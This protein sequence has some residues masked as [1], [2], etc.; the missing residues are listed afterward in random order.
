MQTP[1]PLTPGNYTTEAFPSSIG[2]SGRTTGWTVRDL[3]KPVRSG[4]FAG[5]GNKRR[6]RSLSAASRQDWWKQKRVEPHKL[7]GAADSWSG[8]MV[9]CQEDTQRL[10]GR[11]APIGTSLPTA[12]IVPPIGSIESMPKAVGWTSLILATTCTPGS[13]GVK[14]RFPGGPLRGRMCHASAFSIMVIDGVS[15]GCIVSKTNKCLRHDYLLMFALPMI[16]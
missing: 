16:G 11:P 10:P 2:N 15:A 14:S 4:V 12:T 9:Q 5:Q 7:T 1:S 3:P 13:S 8:S 6:K